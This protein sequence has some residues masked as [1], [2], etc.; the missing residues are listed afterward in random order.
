MTRAAALDFL[1][2]TLPRVVS[3]LKGDVPGH[4]FHGNQYTSGGGRVQPYSRQLTRREIDARPESWVMEQRFN[5]AR[6][7]A[8]TYGFPADRVIY[9]KNPYNFVVDGRK[10]SAAGTYSPFE[11]VIRVYDGG[12]EDESFMPQMMAHEVAHYKFNQVDHYA[13]STRDELAGNH[14][15]MDAHPDRFLPDGRVTTPAQ[16]KYYPEL[17]VT[18]PLDQTRESATQF[19]KLR[20][21]DGVTNY[22]RAY[23]KQFE[24]QG[25]T[26]R[27]MRSN[28]LNETLAEIA[29]YE[30]RHGSLPSGMTKEWKT[31]YDAF[32]R[33][34]NRTQGD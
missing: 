28:A 24:A 32:K 31:Y 26:D 22:S 6:K 10:M 4:P 1:R 20:E 30:A 13:Q 8:E 15:E 25:G 2:L 16:I 5:K 7:M 11:D 21:G 3:R 17:Y 34:Y 14:D 12:L 27:L 19:R 18:R 9:E 23:W 29:G 33:A